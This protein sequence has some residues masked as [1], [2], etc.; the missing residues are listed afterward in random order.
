VGVITVPGR[1]LPP[2]ATDLVQALREAA[3]ELKAA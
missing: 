3:R 1:L 2:P